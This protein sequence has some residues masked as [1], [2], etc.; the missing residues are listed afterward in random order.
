MATAGPMPPHAQL[1]GFLP[2]AEHDAILDW[3]MS[4]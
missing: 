4:E 2:E 3:A 1:L